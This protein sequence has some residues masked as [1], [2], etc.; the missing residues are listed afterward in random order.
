MLLSYKKADGSPVVLRLKTI[1]VAKPVLIGRDAEADIQL[2]DSKCSR[3]HSAIRCWD[4][5]FIIRDMNSR[6]GTLL[7]GKKIDVARLNPGDIIT[8]G[9]TEIKVMAEEGSS[10]DITICANTTYK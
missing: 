10:S 6:N 7:N 9:D 8:V 3:I 5:I 2:E 1:S 4:D